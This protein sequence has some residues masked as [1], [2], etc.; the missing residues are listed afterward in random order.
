MRFYQMPLR[1]VLELPARAF[2]FLCRQINRVSAWE[3]LRRVD[4]VMA[5]S[6]GAG[7]EYITELREGLKKE[8]GVTHVESEEHRQNQSLNAAR[9]EEGL[10]WLKE[11]T[12]SMKFGN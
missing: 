6:F 4:V 11:Q 10:N 5:G 2:W 3:D 9:D 1:E 12:M 8:V 7:G